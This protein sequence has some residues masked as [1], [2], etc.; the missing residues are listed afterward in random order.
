MNFLSE[1]NV[2]G[3]ERV[4]DTLDSVSKDNFGD[5]ESP[6]HIRSAES[7][8]STEWSIVFNLNSG[9]AYYYH[10]ENYGNSYTFNIIN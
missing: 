1:H 6:P 8:E 4:R 5:A 9:T 10:R 2:M 7:F 3:V